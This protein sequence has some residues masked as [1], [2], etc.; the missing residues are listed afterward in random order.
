[1]A[2]PELTGDAPVVAIVEPPEPD[3]LVEFRHDLQ[4]FLAHGLAGTRGHLLAVDIPLVFQERLD[5]VLGTTADWKNCL[6]LGYSLKEIL[7][8]EF[9]HYCFA[10]VEAFH[11]LK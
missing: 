5:D 4:L 3:G 1:M 11:A 9:G 8:F 10:S 2:P 7:L 6:C